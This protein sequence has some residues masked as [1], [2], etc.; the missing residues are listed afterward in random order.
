MRVNRLSLRPFRRYPQAL[1]SVTCDDASECS[2]SASGPRWVVVLAGVPA[3][4]LAGKGIGTSGADGARTTRHCGDMHTVPGK[5]SRWQVHTPAGQRMKA[6][7]ARMGCSLLVAV[8]TVLLV[9]QGATAGAVQAPPSGV[10]GGGWPAAGHDIADTRNAAGEH[11]LG[12]RNVSRLAP[13]TAWCTPDPPHPL[14]PTCTRSTRPTV[15]S[16]GASP[17]AAR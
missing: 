15:T 11:D 16:C 14:V 10:S 12:P 1:P 2:A 9:A 5:A 3:F 8:L 7:S 17:A 13:P 4:L 6:W